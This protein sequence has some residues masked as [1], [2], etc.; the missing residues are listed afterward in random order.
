MPELDQ[1]FNTTDVEEAPAYEPIPINA[2]VK[3]VIVKTDVLRNE[4]GWKGVKIWYQVLEGQHKGKR[5]D[6]LYTVDNPASPN[7]AAIGQRQ[8]KE[9]CE[10]VGIQSFRQTE[11]LHDKIV[12][13]KADQEKGQDGRIYNRAKRVLKAVGN[14]PVPQAPTPAPSAAP[15]EQPAGQAKKPAPWGE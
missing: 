6:A 4:Q 15:P 14:P 7:S 13:C 1:P 5:L 3:A 8:L 10:A 12:V 2:E 11:V 9:V